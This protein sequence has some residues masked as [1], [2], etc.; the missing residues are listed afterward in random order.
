MTT[1]A[2]L[3]FVAGLGDAAQREARA[4]LLDVASWIAIEVGDGTRPLDRVEPPKPGGGF[5]ASITLDEALAEADA[6]V[7]ALE[8]K[9]DA[10][11]GARD[12]RKALALDA[13]KRILYVALEAL[14][15]E[16]VRDV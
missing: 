2:D 6:V 15:R 9:R 4:M 13:A 16:S 1:D 7:D 10:A 11:Q 3:S 14:V 5:L 8:G 12:R